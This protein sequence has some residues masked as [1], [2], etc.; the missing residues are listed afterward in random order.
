MMVIVRFAPNSGRAERKNPEDFSRLLG[1][2]VT[3][4]LELLVLAKAG[5]LP[6][7]GYL[8]FPDR[9]NLV[10]RSS[11][12]RR[13]VAGKRSE[14]DL[15]GFLPGIY[16]DDDTNVACLK[17]VVGNRDRKNHSV[18]FP[19]HDCGYSNGW[20]VTSRRKSVPVSTIQTARIAGD[21]T[22]LCK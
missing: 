13:S 8:I 11:D 1:W 10:G 21:T 22:V 17:P 3:S 6:S 7:V 12:N 16:V 19:N 18:M 20:A 14:L 2:H 5:Q 9:P 15:V 4:P